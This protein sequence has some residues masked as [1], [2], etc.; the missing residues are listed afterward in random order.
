MFIVKYLFVFLLYF[1]LAKSQTTPSCNFAGFRGCA[2]SSICAHNTVPTINATYC[3]L[4]NTNYASGSFCGFPPYNVSSPAIIPGCPKC[5]ILT[6]N[7][8]FC[9]DATD[10]C[11]YW[12][13]YYQ[14]CTRYCKFKDCD[15]KYLEKNY[16]LEN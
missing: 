9:L 8:Y 14:M 1:V 3:V 4:W 10:G 11:I 13:E 2:G 5:G 16:S 7:P 12:D 6:V 15:K